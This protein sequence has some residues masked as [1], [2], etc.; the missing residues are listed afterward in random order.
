MGFDRTAIAAT[1]SFG[2]SAPDGLVGAATQSGHH[3]AYSTQLPPICA[4]RVTSCAL[5]VTV[6]TGSSI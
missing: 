1:A 4:Q 5:S 6:G 3:G 2:I